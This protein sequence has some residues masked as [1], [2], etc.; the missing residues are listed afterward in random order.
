MAVDDLGQAGIERRAVE[1]PVQPEGHGHDV[2]RVTGLQLVEEPE[3][4]LPERH[5]HV[6]I[7]SHSTERRRFP[8]PPRSAA[9]DCIHELIPEARGEH[10]GRIAQRALL[11]VRTPTIG[12]LR[13]DAS[14]R[15]KIY[16]TQ[17]QRQRVDSIGHPSLRPGI[18]I[19]H[20]R[21]ELHLEEL[22]ES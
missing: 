8:A 12:D 16:V 9:V 7:P 3:T 10:A 6:P 17:H 1:P 14:V 11:K 5:R 13:L 21:L 15:M 19:K 4:L 20:T 22:A 18:G 2:G